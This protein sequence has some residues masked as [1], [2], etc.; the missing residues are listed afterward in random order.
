MECGCGCSII[1]NRTNEFSFLACCT[2]HQ[3]LTDLWQIVGIVG[4]VSESNALETNRKLST[5][6]GPHNASSST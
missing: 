5:F 1:E 4:I 3:R 6:V 2:K